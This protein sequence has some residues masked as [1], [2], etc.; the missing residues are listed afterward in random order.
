MK[1]IIGKIDPSDK[2]VTIYGAGFS[3][4]ILGYYLKNEGYKITI[5]EKSNKV[6]GKISTK[7]V[8]GGLV[9]KGPNALYLN[10]DGLELLKELKLEPLPAAKKLK[11]LLM[12]NGKPKRPFQMG[13]LSKLGVNVRKKPPLITDG[14]TVAE[15]FRPLLGDEKINN[16]ISPVL[17]GVYAA[18]SEQ[19]HFRSI[20]DQVGNKAQFESYF[21]FIKLMIRH[22]KAQPKLEVSG[23]VSF[24]GGMQTLIN[25]L[26]E[27]L[28]HDIK[29]NSKEPFKLKH[30][31]IICTDAMTAAD[32]LESVK[33][34]MAKELSRIR[35]TELSSVTV[36]M[37]REIR[38]LT[39]AFGVL[40]PQETGFNSFGIL[41]NK[42]I[43][44][45]NNENMLSYTLIGRKKLNEEDILSDLRQLFP[46]IGKED[47][48]HTEN[49]YWEK[50]LPLYD[51]Q[52][53]LSV[54]KLHQIAQKENNVAVF[55]NYVAGISLREMISAAKTFAKDPVSYPETT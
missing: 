45:A 20:F 11:R 13:L 31:T 27:V 40:I 17:S 3:G 7:K 38:P 9:E 50:A 25:R 52:R 34:E 33:P 19:L 37:K 5:H 10:A 14:L 42:A 6:G 32:L 54:K 8:E 36:F 55:G 51:L 30:N 48:D 49:N 1:R 23:S 53:Y 44:P 46:E 22:Q 41:N 26:A 21:D 39:R 29:L 24:E 47:I 2:H 35:Y 15:F 12:V 18:K 43:F 16:F 28:K 4:L